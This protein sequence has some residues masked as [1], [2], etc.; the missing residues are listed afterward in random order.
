MFSEHLINAFIA[1][2][3]PQVGNVFCAVVGCHI[4]LLTELKD[5]L[6]IIS[7]SYD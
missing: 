1:A 3:F 4:H 6:V 2:V 5:V 7:Y